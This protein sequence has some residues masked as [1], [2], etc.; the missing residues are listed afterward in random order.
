M[1]LEWKN[2]SGWNDRLYFYAQNGYTRRATLFFDRPFLFGKAKI[3][4]QFGLYWVNDKEIG[5]NTVDGI[6]Q[7]A[8]LENDRIR[9][10]FIGTATFGK[11]FGPRRQLQL[12]LSYLYYHLQDSIRDFNP[13]YLTN[14]GNVEHYPSIGLSYIEDQRDW[15]AFP[16]KG[17][18]YSASLRM[19]GFPGLGTS[20]FG[21]AAFAFSHHIPLSRRWNFAYGTQN[22]FLLGNR[23][24]YFDKYF[25]GFGSFWRGYD[26]Y[27]ID[28]PVVI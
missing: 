15:R 5:Y 23:V 26:Y 22:F 19:R 1:G 28:G 6:L 18:K 16:L 17:Y 4:G 12:N 25:I 11:R 14:P 7:L 10:Y 2:V 8:R 3:D 27:V 20:L 9:N 21:K 13:R 24:P